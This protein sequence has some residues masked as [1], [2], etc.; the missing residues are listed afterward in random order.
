MDPLQD[1]WKSCSAYAGWGL[2]TILC[3]R[4]LREGPGL[5]Y[6][7]IFIWKLL[8]WPK[9]IMRLIRIIIIHRA[10]FLVNVPPVKFPFILPPSHTNCSC[11]VLF[12]FPIGLMLHSRIPLCFTV[13]DMQKTF[14]LHHH[15]TWT[16]DFKFLY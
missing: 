11:Q 12:S 8:I 14:F 5:A 2:Y 15:R 3:T 9:V 1:V 10:L 4:H 16:I 6:L 13:F 7:C